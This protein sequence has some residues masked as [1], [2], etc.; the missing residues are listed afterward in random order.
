MWRGGGR[1]GKGEGGECEKERVKRFI[2]GCTDKCY[3]YENEMLIFVP[4]VS[5]P[6]PAISLCIML[7]S[8]HSTVNHT[9][10]PLTSAYLDVH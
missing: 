10:V 1:E 4:I 2:A 9:C 6:F 3:I 8:K 7:A 5:Y